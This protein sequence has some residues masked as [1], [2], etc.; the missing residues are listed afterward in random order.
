MRGSARNPGR[1]GN[2]EGARTPGRRETLNYIRAADSDPSWNANVPKFAA[3]IHRIFTDEELQAYFATATRVGVA[4][5]VC[6]EAQYETMRDA[7]RSAKMR[8]RV[9]PTLSCSSVHGRFS[10]AARARTTCRE[11]TPSLTWIALEATNDSSQIR[12]PG[13]LDRRRGTDSSQRASVV[14]SG[15]WRC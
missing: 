14:A 13:R 15:D 12:L 10:S 5:H 3:E 8:S 7:G 11:A 4:G 1:L 2:T 9:Q 6:T